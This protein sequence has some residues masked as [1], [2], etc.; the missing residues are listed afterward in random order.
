MRAAPISD[1]LAAFLESGVSIAIATRDGDLEP[2][3][4]AGLAAR[5]HED[6]THITLYVHTRAGSALV[7]DLERHPQIAVLFDLPSSHRACQVKGEFT[8]SRRARVSEQ[9]EVMRQGEAFRA[10]LEL[11]GIPRVLTGHWTSWPCVALELR[12]AQ[13]FEQTPGPGTGGLLK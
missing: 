9:N 6:R 5:V 13:V 3:G 11:I 2:D 1:E 4:A 10:D 12:A 8:G 7:R